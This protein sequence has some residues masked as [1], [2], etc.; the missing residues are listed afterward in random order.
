MDY[1]SLRYSKK[2]TLLRNLQKIAFCA[3]SEVTCLGL[4]QI[5]VS[6]LTSLKENIFNLKGVRLNIHPY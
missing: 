4:V 2:Q 6:H 1:L 5:E 3:K